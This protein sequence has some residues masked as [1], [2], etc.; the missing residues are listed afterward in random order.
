MDC[1]CL[2]NLRFHSKHGYFPEERE[3]GNDFEVDVCLCVPLGP[4][5]KRDDLSQTIDYGEVAGLVK[6]V[7]DAEPV[8]LLETL[9][10]A[11]GEALMRNY[12]NA[13]KVDVAIRKMNPP[14][15]PSCD[16]AEVRSQWPKSL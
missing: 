3:N 1:I 14:M 12:P 6:D 13:E 9:L 5:S 15:S 7:M 11:I 10:Y 8:M 4:A 2:K 16:Y